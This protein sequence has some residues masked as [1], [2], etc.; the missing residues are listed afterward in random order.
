VV[1][2]I[3]EVIAEA[4]VVVGHS[5]GAVVGACLAARRPELVRGLFLEDPPFYDLADPERARRAVW[6]PVFEETREVVSAQRAEP[7][8]LGRFTNQVASMMLLLP[9]STPLR[10]GDVLSDA[11]LIMRARALAALDP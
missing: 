1:S 4:C 3:E 8:P 10:L 9:Q 7:E 2:F 11:E 5:L 6:R